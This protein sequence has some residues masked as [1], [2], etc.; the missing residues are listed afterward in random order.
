MCPLCQRTYGPMSE[1]QHKQSKQHKVGSDRRHRIDKYL[2]T[3]L[4]NQTA[5]KA[6]PPVIAKAGHRKM[7]DCPSYY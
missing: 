7:A 6:M 5:R 3:I 1:Y 2:H 4:A